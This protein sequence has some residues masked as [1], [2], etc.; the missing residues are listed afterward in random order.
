MIN[1]IQAKQNAHSLLKKHNIPSIEDVDFLLCYVLNISKAEL[2]NISFI[3][4]KAYKK[5]L[6]TVILRTRH[7]PME[8]IIGFTEFLELQIPFNLKTLTPRKETEILADIVI[9]AIQKTNKQLQVCDLCAG[10]GCIG[11]S[12]AKHTNSEVFLTDIS[13]FSISQIKKNARLNKI[14]NIQ[15]IRSNLFL[16]IKNKFDY[17]VSNPPYIALNEMK[18]LEKEVKHFDPKLAL[19]GGIDGLQLISK[20]ILEAPK[21]LK[22]KGKIYLEIGNNQSSTVKNLLQHKFEDIQTI[23]DFENNIRFIVATLKGENYD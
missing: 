13:K 8:K 16:N 1:V 21:F 5:F 15:I 9:K 17:I 19:Y 23:K 4:K 10:S 22:H 18:K 14:S 6:K 2:V 20:I 11:L 7:V 3:S 12:I